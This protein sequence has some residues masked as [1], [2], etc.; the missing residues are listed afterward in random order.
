MVPRPSFRPPCQTAEALRFIVPTGSHRE[1]QLRA[2]FRRKLFVRRD[3]LALNA[4]AWSHASRGSLPVLT[5][6]G[7]FWIRA[8]DEGLLSLDTFWRNGRWHLLIPH[9]RNSNRP[10]TE[11]RPEISKHS[12][13]PCRPERDGHDNHPI[14]AKKEFDAAFFVPHFPEPPP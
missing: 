4:A 2:S 8:G 14:V 5:R 11:M 9:S 10:K 1:F 13:F 7:Q 12:K 3:W 6:P